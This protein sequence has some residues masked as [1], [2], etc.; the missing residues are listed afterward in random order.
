MIDIATIQEL[1]V[2]VTWGA[3]LTTAF[4][5]V[6]KT[7]LNLDSRWVPATAVAVGV[8]LG[9]IVIGVT[10]TGALVGAIFGLT[11]SGLYDLGKKTIV[12]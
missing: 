5:Q 2:T 1:L 3:P 9:L 11:S 7:T 6:I 8:A 10:V 4:V 12:G